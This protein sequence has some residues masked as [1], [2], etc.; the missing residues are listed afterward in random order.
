MRFST[1]ADKDRR[2]S[3]TVED[4]REKQ[5]KLFENV[6][7]LLD[8]EKKF[9]YSKITEDELSSI[10]LESLSYKVGVWININLKK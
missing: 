5:R 2:I 10:L 4:Q 3:V 9:I 6:I 1:T 7:G 8:I